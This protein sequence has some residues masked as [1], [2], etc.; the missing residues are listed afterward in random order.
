MEIAL[1]NRK[2]GLEWC[3]ENYILDDNDINIIGFILN[4]IKIGWSRYLPVAKRRH[5]FAA[6][7]SKYNENKW[8]LIDSYQKEIQTFQSLNEVN[9]FI[10][11]VIADDGNVMRAFHI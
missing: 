10:H 6:H 7:R 4:S 3:N 9:S 8:L 11:S 1:R 2:I 5:W